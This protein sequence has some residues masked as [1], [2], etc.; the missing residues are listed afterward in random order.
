MIYGACESNAV[1]L[2]EN[3]AMSISSADSDVGAEHTVQDLYSL[4]VSAVA[5]DSDIVRTATCPVCG[6]NEVRRKYLINGTKFEIVN[7]TQ[8]NLGSLWPLPTGNEIRSFYPEDYYGDGGSKFSSVIERVVRMIAARS[9]LFVARSIRRSGRVLDVG[10][11]RGITLRAL[12][13]AGCET[14]GFEVS[15][16]ALRGIDPRVQVTVANSLAQAGYPGGHFDGVLLWHVL[17]HV[18]DPSGVLREAWRI[19]KPGGVVIVAVP[20][21]SSLQATWSG[22]AWFHLD[23]PRHLYHFPITALEQLIT[24]V[25][26]VPISRHHFSLRQN[27]FGWIQSFQNRLPWMPRNGLYA[28]LHRI[29]SNHRKPFTL[30]IRLQLWLCFWILALPSLLLSILAA[31]LRSGA[32]IHMVGR[33]P[34]TN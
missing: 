13:D 15:K 22:A 27:P 16:H 3:D 17:E 28:M 23:P 6:H 10:C 26:F 31:L 30:A 20:N 32:T 21:Y 5:S 1:R 33:K 9:A 8:C 29:E 18:P 2:N 34:L 12:A 24:T 11:G 25:G 7:C 19:L 4:K 14:H